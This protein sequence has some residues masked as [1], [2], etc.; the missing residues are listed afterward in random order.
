VD[1]FAAHLDRWKLT[2]DGAGDAASL[3][4]RLAGTPAT[5]RL[6]TGDSDEASAARALRHFGGHGAVKVLR[7]DRRAVLLQRAVPGTPLSSLVADGRDHEATEILVA[8]MLRLHHGRYPPKGWPRVA[9]LGAAFERHRAAGSHR[10][11]PHRL[12]ERGQRALHD[13]AETQGRQFLLH[14]DLHHDRVVSDAREGWLAVEPRALVGEP[15]YETA[16]ALRGPPGLYL[17][18]L[19]RELMRRRVAIFAERL[20]VDPARILGWHLAGAVLEVL[21]LAEAH[22][23]ETALVHAV[24]IAEAAV[25]MADAG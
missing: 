13:L 17:V 5:L 21:R 23:P 24:R 14:G 16:A 19:D 12:V 18:Q 10:H 6:L 15:A 22:A 8:L 1:D 20:S 3:P 11:V 25:A 9:D 4:V 2:R 7:E